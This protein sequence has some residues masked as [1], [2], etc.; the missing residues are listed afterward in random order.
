MNPEFKLKMQAYLD[1]ELPARE[2]KEIEAQIQAVPEAQALLTELRFTLA[3]LRGNEPEYRVPETRE[4]YWSQIERLILAAEKA[5]R[6]RRP[7]YLGWLFRYWPQ[8]SGATVA[9]LLLIVAAA[10]FHWFS[11]PMWEDIENP[12]AET[13]TFWF[14]SDSDRITLVWVSEKADES[15]SES[16]LVN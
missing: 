8:L 2:A 1:G 10:Q 5:D 15:E 7:I 3:T 11:R 4:F 13:S 12:L 14:R 16:E 9:V 6:R